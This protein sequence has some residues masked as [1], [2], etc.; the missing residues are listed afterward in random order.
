MKQFNVNL[1]ESKYLLG[2]TEK[3][4]GGI[5]RVSAEV[6]TNHLQN[7]NLEVY[8]NPLCRYNKVVAVQ[9]TWGVTLL[10]RYCSSLSYPKAIR[11]DEWLA[12]R[13]DRWA[14]A[15]YWLSYPVFL[16][17][18]VGIATGYGLDDR[19]VRVRV[20]VGSRIL[21]SPRRPERP[22][23]SLSLLSNGYRGLF[24]ER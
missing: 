5:A 21:S 7:T 3:I 18:A 12:S 24:H 2:M 23:D 22:W 6:R 15:L 11:I 17:V 16:F 1:S 4:S 8:M 9:P 20:T 19:G 14:W 10:W 13:W